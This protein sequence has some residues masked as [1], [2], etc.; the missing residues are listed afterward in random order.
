MVKCIY[1]WWWYWRWRCYEAY[2]YSR[3]KKIN[4]LWFGYIQAH[5]IDD[6]DECAY[7]Y[8]WKQSSSN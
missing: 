6:V 4:E 7:D 1:L 5:R 3:N 8:F 2:R